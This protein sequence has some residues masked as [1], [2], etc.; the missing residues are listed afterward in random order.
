MIDGEYQ[1]VNLID[2]IAFIPRPGI[3]NWT[4][5]EAYTSVLRKLSA[6]R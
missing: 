6:Q 1:S 4:Q 3:P 5:A 2:I